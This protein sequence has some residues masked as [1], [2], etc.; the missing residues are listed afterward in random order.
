MKLVT[1]L[2][3][4]A[5]CALWSV[6]PP[7][8]GEE[9]E[10]ATPLAGESFKTEVLGEPVTVRSRDRKSVTAASFGLQ[11]LHDGPSFYQ[12]LPFGAMYVWRNSDDERRRFRGTFS[13]AVNDL[14]MNVGSSSSSGLELRFTFNNMIIP[15]GRAEYVEGQIIPGVELEWNYVFAGFG[16]AYR[17]LLS[18][19]H[20][21]NAFEMSLTY[22]PGYRWFSGSKNTSPNFVVPTD[23]Y[24]GR[25][26]ARVRRDALERN[27]MELPHRGYAF[28]G[29]FF[30]GERAHWAPWG[31]G[32]VFD[33][34]DANKERTYLMGSVFAVT[35]S[36]VPFVDSERHRLITSFYGGIGR[37]LDRFS[38]F[39]LPGRPTGYEW[40]AL[41]LPMLPSVAFNELA[42]QRYGIAH[43]EYRYE[44]FFFMYPYVRGSWGIV[45]EARFQP[46]GHVRDKMDSLPALSGGIVSGAPWNSQIELNYSYNFGIFSDHNGGQPTPGRHGFFVFWAREFGKSSSN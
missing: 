1:V 4:I 25:V 44:S 7:A 38:T 34:P 24:E 16:L 42:P 32:G 10:Q 5:F 17:T 31:G 2:S 41:A 8:Y 15:F 18:P 40:E 33:R 39:R 19:G 11:Y 9:K 45:E 21:D 13:G 22:E 43:I 37:D 3:S 36:G 26:H 27:L 20:Q 23:T 29:D 12:I 6:I 30:Y 14:A 35:A 46:N 28:G